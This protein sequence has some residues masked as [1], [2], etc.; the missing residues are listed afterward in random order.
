MALVE[1]LLVFKAIAARPVDVE[2][3]VTAK[4]GSPMPTLPPGPEPARHTQGDR[5]PP[6]PRSTRKSRARGATRRSDGRVDFDPQFPPRAV[7][8]MLGGD[9]SMSDSSS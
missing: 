4:L 3:A 7:P 1:D 2:D 9:D 8:T 6:R 5:F